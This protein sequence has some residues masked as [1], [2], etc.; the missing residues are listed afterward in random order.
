MTIKKGTTEN[1]KHIQIAIGMSAKDADGNFG[2]MTE[3]FVKK[4][5][6]TN[7]LIS[8]G[9]I[10]DVDLEIMFPKSKIDI[11][12]I[13]ISKLHLPQ[14][15]ITQL[16][17]VMERFNINT[18]LRLA[19]FLSQCSHESGSFKVVNENLNYSEAGLKATF[20]KYFKT[21]SASSYAK[22]PEKIASL[23]YGGRMGNGPESTKDGW[24]FRGRGFIQ[25]TGK[26]NYKEFSKFIGEDCVANPDLVSTKYPLASAAF[27][28]SHNKLWSICDKGSS[29]PVIT[30]LTRRINGGD[31]GLN[32]RISEFKE[33][34]QLIQ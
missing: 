1:I 7:N 17:F 30:E 34:Y 16:P 23:V 29:V 12:K 25:L 5:Q 28:F 32:D 15:V 11:S 8:D 20:G 3:S 27:F 6:T 19:H 18:G 33:I 22:N 4:W 21:I 14:S 26:D 24:T 9:I 10:K 31:N 2:P 13:D